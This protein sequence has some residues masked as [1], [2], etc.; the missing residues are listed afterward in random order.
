MSRLTTV[1]LR[2]TLAALACAAVLAAAWPAGDSRAQEEITLSVVD[3]GRRLALTEA[4]EL[5]IVLPANPST[6]FVWQVAELD[7]RIL[8]A[9]DPGAMT[10]AD[11]AAPGMAAQQVL[12]FRAIGV[13]A[14]DLQLIYRRPWETDAAPAAAFAVTVTG[15]GP[16][17][18]A[19]TPIATPTSEPARQLAVEPVYDVNGQALPGHFNWCDQGGC[20]PIK[21]QGSC[22]SCWAFATAG[23]FELG[24]RIKDGVTKD[25]SEQYL[26]SCNTEGYSCQGGLWAHR[27][28]MDYAPWGEPAGFLNPG[29]ELGARYWTQY[30]WQGWDVIVHAND[31]PIGP[32]AGSWAAWLGG[33]DNE[34]SYVEQRVTVPSGRPYLTYWHRIGSEDTCGYDF[35]GVVVNHAQVIDQYDL[36]AAQATGRWVRHSVNLSPYAGKT[37]YLQ[38]RAETDGSKNSNLFVD[39]VSFQ[40]TAAVE[41]DGPPVGG[42]L[43]LP[44]KPARSAP[45]GEP[46]PAGESRLL[47]R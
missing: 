25:L 20:T 2:T 38:I 22:G 44:S 47:G 29:F 43:D 17:T 1:I 36:C 40:A 3:N 46:A 27:Y 45:R 21:D 6:G 19:N 7:T 28:H 10:Y 30:S 11:D 32:H 33:A 34:I 8:V 12:R 37:I 42:P 31:L 18:G 13:G 23:V 24:I 16:F 14:T 26:V 35:G 4:H 5:V 15:L 39:D 9:V 41:E